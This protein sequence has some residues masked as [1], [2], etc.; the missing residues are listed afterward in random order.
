[1]SVS[2]RLVFRRSQVGQKGRHLVKRSPTYSL[3]V[4]GKKIIMTHFTNMVSVEELVQC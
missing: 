4:P 1:M 3:V 2:H